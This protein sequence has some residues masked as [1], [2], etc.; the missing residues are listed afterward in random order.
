MSLSYYW[1]TLFDQKARDL[2]GGDLEKL[3]R[4]VQELLAV[5]VAGRQTD[6][7]DGGFGEDMGRYRQVQV[8]DALVALRAAG[9]NLAE[10]IFIDDYEEP[11]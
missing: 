11:S 8:H 10:A 7:S 9:A 4:D 3:Q 5:V 2:Y 6:P 1:K